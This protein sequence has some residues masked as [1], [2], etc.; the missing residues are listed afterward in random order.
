MDG[1]FAIQIR[2]FTAGGD[3]LVDKITSSLNLKSAGTRVCL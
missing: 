3:A 2:Y 1:I